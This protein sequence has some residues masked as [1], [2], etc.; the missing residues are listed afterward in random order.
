MTT[1]VWPIGVT[2]STGQLGG[3]VATRLAS[4][5]QT[6]RLLVRNPA[7][8]PQL[9]GAEIIQ[10]SYEDGASMKVALSG[11]KVLFL[12]SG[13][14]PDRL[15]QHYSAIDAAVAARVE[16]IVY[17]SFLSAAPLATFSHAREHYL[18]EHRIRE[19]GC[20]HTFL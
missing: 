4:L 19:S 16:R 15:E 5:G 2:G 3:R 18:T 13:F 7:R 11:I 14:G 6:Q 1:S 17:T 9:P 12:V 20:R 10:A 8:A